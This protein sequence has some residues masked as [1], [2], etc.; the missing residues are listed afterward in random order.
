M[1]GPAFD[2]VIAALE[3]AGRQPRVYGSGKATAHCPG[4]GHDRGD[5]HPSLKISPG[6]DGALVYC[7][8]LCNTE[9]VL[10]AIGLTMA[11]LFDEPRQPAPQAPATR[12]LRTAIGKARGL[13]DGDRYLYLWLLTLANW[14]TAEIPL[15][16]QPRSQRVLAAACGLNL[17]SVKQATRHLVLHHWLTVTCGAP[18]CKRDDLH[19]GAGHRSAYSFPGIG[20]DCPG[21]DC[22]TRCRTRKGA[23]RTHLKVVSSASAITVI[24]LLSVAGGASHPPTTYLQRKPAS[25]LWLCAPRAPFYWLQSASFSGR[26]S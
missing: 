22:R 2:R 14:D 26:A 8:A 17:A 1:T 13:S 24:T 12:Q 5:Q 3:A 10:A 19:P 9:D 23:R 11:E 6:K 4:P 15:P 18:G 25:D 7:F 21:G 20:G 16:F